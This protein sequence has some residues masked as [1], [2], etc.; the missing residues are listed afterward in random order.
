MRP[1][2]NFTEIFNVKKTDI[3]SLY[4]IFKNHLKY[5]MYDRYLWERPTNI[6]RSFSLKPNVDFFSSGGEYI[7][8]NSITDG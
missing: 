6:L 2:I 4:N 5:F 3:S 1:E 8:I 7:F